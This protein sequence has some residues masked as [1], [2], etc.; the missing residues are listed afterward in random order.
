MGKLPLQMAWSHPYK[1]LS[2]PFPG[3]TA[4]T[5]SLTV[6]SPTVGKSSPTVKSS[7]LWSFSVFSGGLHQINLVHQNLT[8]GR[9]ERYNPSLEK[10]GQWHQKEAQLPAR[11]KPIGTSPFSGP[12]HADTSGESTPAFDILA[13]LQLAS[14]HYW[15]LQPPR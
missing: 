2:Y 11:P 8:G 14:A 12:H 10:S 5:G 7:F 15:G 6:P 3:P 4:Y 13:H 9:P 1:S